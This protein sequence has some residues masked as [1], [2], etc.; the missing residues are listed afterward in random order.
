VAA[1]V[2]HDKAVYAGLAD[3]VEDGVKAVVECASVDAG[4][5]L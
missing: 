4:E 3:G 2:D 5:V 1:L